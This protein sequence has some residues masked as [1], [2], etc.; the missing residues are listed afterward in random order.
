MESLVEDNRREAL[1]LSLERDIAWSLA[2]SLPSE[3]N[4][5]ELPLLGSWTGFNKMVTDKAITACVYEYL[6]VSPEPPEYPYAKVSGFFAGPDKNSRNSIC[7][8]T[9][10]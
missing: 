3:M 7:I 6:P 5:E 2:G 1:D 4:G 8:R 10:R 9:L